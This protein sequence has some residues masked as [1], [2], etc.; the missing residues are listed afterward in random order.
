MDLGSRPVVVAL[1][2]LVASLAFSAFFVDKMFDG[3]DE[4]QALLSGKLI[5]Q[6]EVL[7]TQVRNIYTPGVFLIGALVHVLFAPNEI[8]F[9]RIIMALFAA[10]AGALLYLIARRLVPHPY[11]LLPPVLLLIWGIPFQHYT[12]PTWPAVF[13][14]VLAV[15]FIIRNEESGKLRHLL[16]AGFAVGASAFFKQNVGAYTLAG[17][18][19]YFAITALA[20]NWPKVKAVV[21]QLWDRKLFFAAAAVIPLLTVGY[22]TATN[23]FTGMYDMMVVRSATQGSHQCWGLPFPTVASLI[24]P[25]L[26]IESVYRS[27]INSVYYAVLLVYFAALYYLYRNRTLLSKVEGKTLLLATLVALFQF[28]MVVYPRTDRNH[29]IFSMLLAYIIAAYLLY[30]LAGG[31]AKATGGKKALALAAFAYL[32]FFA[33]LGASLVAFTYRDYLGPTEK[34]AGMTIPK[35]QIDDFKQ[36]TEYISANAAPGEEIYVASGAASFYLVTGHDP[37]SSYIQLYPG[38]TSA[39]AVQAEI[40]NDIRT[41]NAQFAIT[42]PMSKVDRC[43]VTEFEGDLYNYIGKDFAPV[44]QFGNYTILKRK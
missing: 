41:S 14:Q 7:Y 8:L 35:G 28:H 38:I 1:L 26:A 36:A 33:L 23:S 3:T 10:S 18:T 43:Y 9:A 4:G 17:I 25:S 21:G 11:A 42:S 27:A 6:G 16:L 13:F 39:P 32:A 30:K 29:L 20:K 12:T 5:S 15:Y 24:P 19:V 44:T 34:F 22:F 37:A 31:F 2:V 40:I